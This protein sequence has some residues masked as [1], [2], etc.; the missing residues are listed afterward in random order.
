M[1]NRQAYFAESSYIDN[2]LIDQLLALCE[3]E[4]DKQALKRM[5]FVKNPYEQA[6]GVLT[7]AERKVNLL[8][9]ERS[10]SIMEEGFLNEVK[11]L[12]EKQKQAYLKTL[13]KAIEE[14]DYATLAKMRPPQNWGVAKKYADAMK[15]MF[16]T[17]KKTASDEMQVI[18][19]NT[20]KDVQGLFRAQALQME[21]KIDNEMAVTAQSEARYN[22]A[23]G[24]AVDITMEQVE[25]ALDLKLGKIIV[26]SGTQAIGG[27][28]NT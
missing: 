4:A 21:D 13:R 25:K 19:P 17:G 10:F 12:T 26:A 18:A 11:D 20:D 16:E 7:M 2:E 24:V 1:P 3:S 27:A 22:I 8:S 15:Q 28:F 5:G 23:K 14:K 6:A 9:I